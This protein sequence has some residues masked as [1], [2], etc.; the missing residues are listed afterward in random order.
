MSRFRFEIQAESKDSRARAGRLTTLH[1]LVET[2]VFMPVGTLATVRSQTID[3]LKSVGSQVLLA[4]TYHLMLQPGPEV[5]QKF[6]GIHRFMRWDRPVLTDSGGFQVFSLSKNC[7][8]TEEGATFQDHSDGRKHFLSPEISIQMQKSIGSDIMMVLDE[9]IASTAEHAQARSAMER[10]HRWARRS[11]SARTDSPQALFGIVQGACFTDLRRESAETLSELPFEG[12]AIGG[13]AVGE[14]TAEREDVTEFT[15]AL[16]P[17]EKPRYL[18][19]V[20]TPIDILE[21]VHR[22]VDMFD[23]ILPVAWAQRGAAFTSEGKLQLRRTA[24]RLSEDRLDPVCDCAT[25]SVY[26]RA[27]LHHLHKADEVLG[28]TLIAQHNLRYYHRLMADLR[29]AILENRFLSLYKIL[30][31]QFAPS[32]DPNQEE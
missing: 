24:Y 30:K 23:C 27:Y 5:F 18:M 2:P 20:G 14:S 17:R 25:C 1:G 29:L 9:C 21:G 4:N 12:M 32:S 26:S 19:G 31:S 13:L 15:T 6:G 3:S 10:T 8:M 11:L 28:W 22:G 7:S 16:L